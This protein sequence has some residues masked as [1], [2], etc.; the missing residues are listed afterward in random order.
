MPDQ[1]IDIHDSI[2]QQNESVEIP[3]QTIE[4][5]QKFVADSKKIPFG[6]KMSNALRQTIRERI[7]VEDVLD[8]P[9]KGSDSHE[10]SETISFKETWNDPDAQELDKTPPKMKRLDLKELLNKFMNK[11]NPQQE[12]KLSEFEQPPQEEQPQEQKQFSPKEEHHAFSITLEDPKQY[13]WFVNGQAA[14]SIPDM[15]DIIANSDEDVF[16]HHVSQEKNDLAS[17]VEG[18]FES[19]ELAA[20]I[21][22]CKTKQDLLTV[23]ER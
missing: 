11:H 18:V 20:I 19:P 22:G 10:V 16:H 17:W 12:K 14:K 8:V 2:S 3:E 7:E 5:Q 23:F 6:V 1:K 4:Q 15:L 13:F 21:A 9:E